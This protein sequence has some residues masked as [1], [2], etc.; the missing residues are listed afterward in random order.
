MKYDTY[1]AYDPTASSQSLPTVLTIWPTLSRYHEDLVLV[2][3]LVPTCICKHPAKSH[4]LPRPATLD[5]DLGIA[6]GTSAGQYSTVCSD[7]SRLGFKADKENNTRF[8]KEVNGLE[9][10]VDFLVEDG[11]ASEGVRMVDDVQASVM[12]GIGRALEIARSIP[13][14]GKDLYGS[15]QQTLARVCEVGPFLALKLRAFKFRQH[16]KD[17]FDILYT[18]KHYDQGPEAAIA[19]FSGEVKLGNPACPDA[20]DTLKK[21]FEEEDSSGP[22]RAAHFVL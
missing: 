2:G 1:S 5:V 17:A 4:E 7:L 13:M 14:E 6:L 3:G 18:V 11:N 19:A 9:M 12:P 22:M 8:V 10:Y 16:P 20:I 21:D 15:K